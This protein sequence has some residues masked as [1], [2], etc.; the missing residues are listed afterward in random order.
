MRGC[1]PHFANSDVSNKI[2]KKNSLKEEKGVSEQQ[3]KVLRLGDPTFSADQ[4]LQNNDGECTA[5][6]DHYVILNPG[7]VMYHPAGKLPKH[8][9]AMINNCLKSFR[10]R[11]AVQLM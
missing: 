8:L 7:D 3:L 4:Y 5:E 6:G 9:Y 1:T 2:E 10:L 11:S